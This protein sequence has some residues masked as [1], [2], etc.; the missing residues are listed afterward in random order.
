MI[1]GGKGFFLW[2]DFEVSD[3]FKES[4]Q[5]QAFRD[6]LEPLGLKSS[7]SGGGIGLGYRDIDFD[8]PPG[9]DLHAVSQALKTDLGFKYVA[10]LHVLEIVDDEEDGNG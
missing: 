4:Q 2:I 5:E 7:G 8:L 10:R 3:D 1:V 6:L 9:S